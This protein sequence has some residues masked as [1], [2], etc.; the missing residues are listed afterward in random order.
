M[1]VIAIIALTCAA[2]FTGAAGYIT[3]VEHPARLQLADGPLLAQWK[4]SYD[5]ALPIQSGLAIAGGLS[6]MGA[7]Y[8]SGAVLWVMGS[9]ILL[10]NWPFTLL[11]IMPTN[12]RLK[13][14]E[15]EDAGP[16]TRALLVL[17]GKL[18]AIRSVLGVVS[19]VLFAAALA[20]TR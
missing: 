4:P 7:W 9:L 16:T 10:A 19:M 15:P 6:G 8:L 14:I 17:W 2:L 3:L 5:R 20:V 12:K 13:M 18:H 1:N 11:A